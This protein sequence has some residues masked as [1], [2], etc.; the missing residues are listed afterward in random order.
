MDLEVK[1]ETV[2]KGHYNLNQHYKNSKKK[3]KK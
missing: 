3:G 2:V 1:E